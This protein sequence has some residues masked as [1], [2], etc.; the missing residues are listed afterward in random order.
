M[1]TPEQ[2]NAI[3]NFADDLRKCFPIPKDEDGSLANDIKRIWYQYAWDVIAATQWKY[4]KLAEIE[5]HQE[6]I[7]RSMRDYQPVHPDNR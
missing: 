1:I 7:R 6:D 4:K 3:D 2:L 5:E